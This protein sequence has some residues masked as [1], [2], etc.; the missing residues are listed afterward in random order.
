[1]SAVATATLLPDPRPRRHEEETLHRSAVQFM[2]QALPDDATFYHVPN[3]GLRS[4]KVAQ[5]LSGL[6]VVAGVPDLAVV[7][8]GHAIFIELKAGRGTLSAAQRTMVRKLIYC[9]ADVICA[10]SLP[11]IEAA[12]R[13]AGVPLKAT[14]AA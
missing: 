10:R 8:K 9:G 3:G 4:R 12:L 7:H 1:V 5:R 6:G 2:R 13:G 11:D 14:V